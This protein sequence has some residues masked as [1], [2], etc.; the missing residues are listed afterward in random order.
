MYRRIDD[1]LRDWSDESAATLK[2]F[3]HLTDAA[4]AQRVTPEG[5]TAGRL[6]WHITQ[7][8]PQMAREA[9][10]T[11]KGPADADPMPATI[12]EIGG[13]YGEA[14]CSFSGAVKAEWTDDLL[15]AELPMYGESWARGKILSVLIRHEV[16][17]RAQL[18]VLMRQAGLIVPG[19]YG[20]AR[21]EWAAYG[22]EPQE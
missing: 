12:E 22:A 13:R 18:T 15:G 6:A 17:H 1:F 10:L 16:H 2:V 11:V 14:A 5:R 4:L 21:E 19:V 8:V 20:P 3:R 9:G 7:S